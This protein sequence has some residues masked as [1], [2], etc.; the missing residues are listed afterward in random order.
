MKTR[1]KSVKIKRW[2]RQV[3]GG[4]FLPRPRESGSLEI[5]GGH[6]WRSRLSRIYQKRNSVSNRKPKK[7]RPS[8]KGQLSRYHFRI[9]TSNSA[10]PQVGQNSNSLVLIEC[11][12]Q[13]SQRIVSLF[14]SVLVDV[15]DTTLATKTRCARK[16]CFLFRKNENSPLWRSKLS[17][18]IAPTFW[19]GAISR[20][21]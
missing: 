18:K 1:R 11:Q 5:E 16:C 21:G 15:S 3:E 7:N 9:L 10:T 12:P 17:K 6:F 8:F 19:V 14:L 2:S 4:H 13:F 20:C